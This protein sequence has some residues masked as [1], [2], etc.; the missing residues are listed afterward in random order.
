MEELESRFDSFLPSRD[1][2]GNGE[3]RTASRLEFTSAEQ[4]QSLERLAVAVF[5]SWVLLGGPHEDLAFF[6]GTADPGEPA[7]PG[8]AP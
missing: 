3:Q 1:P 6:L 5:G 4:R 7:G 8:E 2:D